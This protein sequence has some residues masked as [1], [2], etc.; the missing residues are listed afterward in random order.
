LSFSDKYRTTFVKV[1]KTFTKTDKIK[2][3]YGSFK[4]YDIAKI[5]DKLTNKSFYTFITHFQK[6][7]NGCNNDVHVF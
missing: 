2:I 4:L 5:D 1:P 7:K 3:V 6:R